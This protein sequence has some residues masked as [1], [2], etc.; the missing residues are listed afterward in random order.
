[1]KCYKISYKCV[2]FYTTF[3]FLS[4]N[5]YFLIFLNIDYHLNVKKKKTIYFNFPKRN[6]YG[7]I[8]LGIKRKLKKCAY[9]FYWS[10]NQ[11][12]HDCANLFTL[13]LAYSIWI[14]WC[15]N[16]TFYDR[17]MHIHGTFLELIDLICLKKSRTFRWCML[18]S[19]C[20][21]QN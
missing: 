13:W 19:S 5:C 8:I 1:M 3:F 18:I 11:I 9:S 17:K 20:R 4:N 6:L 7:F 15:R 21:Q 16:W 10:L 12:G 2:I 14:W